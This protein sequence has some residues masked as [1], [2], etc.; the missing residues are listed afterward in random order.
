M[1]N[2]SKTEKKV[3]QDIYHFGKSYKQKVKVTMFRRIYC[4]F[5]GEEL[6]YKRLDPAEIIVINGV[7]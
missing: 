6:E 7:K 3:L 4:F 1:S 2:Y 5:T